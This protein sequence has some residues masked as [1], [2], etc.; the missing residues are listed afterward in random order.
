MIDEQ[1]PDGSSG[2]VCWAYDDPATF[3]RSAEAYLTAGLAAG[4]RVWYISP[5]EPESVLAR[6]RGVPAIA[7]ALRRGAAEVVPLGSTYASDWTVDPAAQVA[8]YAAAT[9]QALAAGHTGLRV[10]AEATALVRTPAQLDAFARYEHQ[11]DRYM[12][13]RPFRAMCAYHRP[14]LGARAVAELASLHPESNV[15]ELLFRLYAVAP[16]DG[17]A[18]LAGELDPSQHELFGTALARADLRPTGGELVLR[19]TGL[20]FLDHRSLVHLDEYA[21]RRAATAVLRTGRPALARLVDLLDLPRVR[22]E[23]AR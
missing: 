5:D 11:V 3:R 16:G 13:S 17:H 8:A 21:H 4:E 18:A 12:R 7:D 10:V 23:V 9:E 15:E 22:V 19:A 1:R 14:E 6:L 2:H 20:R